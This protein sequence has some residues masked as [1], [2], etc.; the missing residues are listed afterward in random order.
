MKGKYIIGKVI[1]GS[2]IVVACV[3]AFM[4]LWNW[5]ITD[6]FSLRSI[7]IYES[8]GLLVMSKLVFMVCGGSRKGRCCSKNYKCSPQDGGGKRELRKHFFAKYCCTD[9]EKQIKEENGIK[10]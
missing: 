7:T 8:I 9:E 5:L 10:S 2:I 6:I 4:H 1:I 3:F